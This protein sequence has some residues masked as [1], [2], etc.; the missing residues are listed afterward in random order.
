MKKLSW[1]IRRF[2]V[3]EN[4]WNHLLNSIRICKTPIELPKFHE[5]M[6]VIKSCLFLFSDDFIPQSFLASLALGF[7]SQ[8]MPRSRTLRD[9]ALL[10][11]LGGLAHGDNNSDNNHNNQVHND[12]P[13]LFSAVHVGGRQHCLDLPVDCCGRLLGRLGSYA[14]NSLSSNVRRQE[15]WPLPVARML[16][17]NYL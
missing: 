3:T 12:G 5:I 1:K 14:R 16:V 17:S 15:A 10:G 2:V 8:L 7:S 6:Y 13:I 11:G 4:S 9:V